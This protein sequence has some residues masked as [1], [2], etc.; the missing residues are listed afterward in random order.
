MDVGA[1]GTGA[2]VP[3]PHFSQIQ[4]SGPFSCNLVEYYVLFTWLNYFFF[5]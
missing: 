1:G 5:S 2:R 4:T 3:P